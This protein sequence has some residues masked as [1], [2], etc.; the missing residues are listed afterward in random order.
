MT[1]RKKWLSGLL[2]AAFLTLGA[3][4]S[5]GETAKDNEKKDTQQEQ[6][7]SEQSEG[8]KEGKEGG[9]QPKMPEPDL[10]GTPDVVAEV[11]GEK[12]KKKEFEA[13]YKSQFQQAALQS[14]MS[15]Q[16]VDQDKLKKQM[17]DSLVGQELLIQEAN[18]R[19]YKATQEKKD[20]ILEDLA[21]Q[22]KAGSKEEFLAQLEKQ[23]MSEKEVMS[24]LETQVKVEQLIAAEAGDIEPTE[25]EMKKMYEQMKAQQEQMGG[26]SKVPSFEEAKPSLKQQL[27]QQ[28]EAE[29]AQKLIKNLREDADVKVH[30]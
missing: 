19:D 4:S 8:N 7:S 26:E 25:E 2:F 13:A 28:K 5:D 10:K 11:N 21:K 17:V 16:K 18:N 30:I 3:C 6:K 14:Q 24:Q 27:K 23:G 9:E 20:K 22:N 12:I 1:L 15:G 29:E